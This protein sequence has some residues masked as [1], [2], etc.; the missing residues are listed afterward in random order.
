[1]DRSSTSPDDFIPRR[2]DRTPGSSSGV[3][4]PSP[5]SSYG[6]TDEEEPMQYVLLLYA[7]EEAWDSLDPEAQEAVMAEYDDVTEAMK[8]QSAHLGGEALRPSSEAATLRIRDGQEIVTDGPFV[9]AKE[10]LG[11]FYLVE[12]DTREEALRWAARIPDA[13]IGAIEVR[14]ILDVS[15]LRESATST[16]SEAG[17][18]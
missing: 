16:A 5:R 7:E 2:P 6:E 10:M 8:A 11:G 3:E 15:D 17:A 1:M 18:G 13:R 4:M 12:C 14:P 9:E